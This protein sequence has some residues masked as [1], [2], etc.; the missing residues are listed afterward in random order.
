M[1]KSNRLNVLLAEI[2]IATLFFALASTV[3]LKVY[4]VTHSQSILAEAGSTAQTEMR[5]LSEMCYAAEDAEAVL[6]EYGFVKS[7]DR[8]VYNSDDYTLSAVIETEKTAAG[9]LRT[10]LFSAEVMG[11][12][13]MSL[14]SARYF[15]EVT[16]Q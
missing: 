13:G 12:T 16:A 2:I 1:K 4:T 5:N 7:E 10:I 3:I 14:P 6:T 11:E 9:T 15:P 8:Y